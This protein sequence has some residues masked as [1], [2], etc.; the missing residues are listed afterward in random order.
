MTRMRRGFDLWSSMG[1]FPESRINS[2]QY[3]L[4]APLLLGEWTEEKHIGRFHDSLAQSLEPLW[5]CLVPKPDSEGN[6]LRRMHIL[7]QG[8]ILCGKFTAL[9]SSISE[10]YKAREK[11][12]TLQAIE[13]TG[14]PSLE[15]VA[16][17][18]ATHSLVVWF[19][20]RCWK[21]RRP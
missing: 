4:V 10:S 7:I 15:Y 1:S 5:S 9:R 19:K 16:I 6:E 12:K 3:L 8:S 13:E 14:F 2:Q 18:S 17:A 11:V 20:A 21:P